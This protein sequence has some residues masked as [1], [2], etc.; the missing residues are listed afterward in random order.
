MLHDPSPDSERNGEPD[1]RSGPFVPGLEPWRMQEPVG[2][3]AMWSARWQIF[4]MSTRSLSTA[5][6]DAMARTAVERELLALEREYW[7]AIKDK[8]ADTA[9]R[10]SDDPCIV[11][12]AQGVGRMDNKTLAGMMKSAP[13]TLHEFKIGDDA[14]VH[15]LG[16]DVAILA[17]NVHEELTVDGKLVALDAADASTWV[18]RN[19]R[20]VCALHTESLKGDPFGRDRRSV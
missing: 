17:Y 2:S 11:T 7:Q 13:Y 18:R 8:D 14:Q 19:G 3:S 12:G 16:D 15:L 10:L 20:W 9:I 4:F 5:K 1:A 6:E